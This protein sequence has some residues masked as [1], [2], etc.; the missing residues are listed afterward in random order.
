MKFFKEFF[1]TL[2]VF[3]GVFLTEKYLFS[4]W[5]LYLVFLYPLYR[6]WNLVKVNFK[7]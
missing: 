5:V 1:I 2:A 3:A 4:H 6:W 7:K